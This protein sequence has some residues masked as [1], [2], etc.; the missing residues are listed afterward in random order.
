MDITK[1]SFTKPRTPTELSRYFSEAYEYIRTHSE[2]R[3]RARLKREPYKTFIEELLPFSIYCTWKYGD[4]NDVLCSLVP[5]TTERDGIIKD[6]RT[7]EE[8]SIEITW[9][10]DG[11]AHIRTANESNEKGVAEFTTRNLM[12]T[13]ENISAI[14]KVLKIAQKKQ[15][16]D[17]R[18][19]G[20]STLLIVFEKSPLFYNDNPEHVKVFKAMINAIEKMAFKVDVVIVLDISRKEFI[21]LKN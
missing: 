19:E 13:T 3:K 20:S 5:G 4:R 8:H 16:R 11:E 9:P 18:T 14:K 6:L 1:E 2:I 17:Y 10:I 21:T 7:G 12:D 15:L